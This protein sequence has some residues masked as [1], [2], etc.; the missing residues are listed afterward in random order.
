MHTYINGKTETWREK[1]KIENE[2]HDKNRLRKNL[3]N[4]LLLLQQWN[5]NRRKQHA[6]TNVNAIWNEID[7]NT[8]NCNTRDF[9]VVQSRSDNIANN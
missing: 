5:G 8:I 3:N 2:K 7:A 4:S 1:E 6:G 9:W